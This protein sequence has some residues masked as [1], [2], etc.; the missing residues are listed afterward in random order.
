MNMIKM[1]TCRAYSNL[2]PRD[3]WLWTEYKRIRSEWI[4]L[5]EV[6]KSM[7]EEKPKFYWD[8]KEAR[9]RPREDTSRLT[10]YLRQ[11]HK[12]GFR[13]LELALYLYKAGYIAPDFTREQLAG[14]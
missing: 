7:P 9:W 8:R 5:R 11:E 2:S 6:I 14:K 13:L 4:R 1:R 3:K 12:L 10:H